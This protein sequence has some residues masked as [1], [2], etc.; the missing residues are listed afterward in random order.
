MN[1]IV[2][3][4]SMHPGPEKDRHLVQNLKFY[5]KLN[6]MVADFLHPLMYWAIS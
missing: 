6:G 2:S 5:A 4:R 1:L 3:V